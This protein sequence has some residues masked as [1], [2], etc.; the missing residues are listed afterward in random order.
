MFARAR[1]CLRFLLSMPLIG[2]S[3]SI[4]QVVVSSAVPD[5]R[6]TAVAGPARHPVLLVNPRAGDGKAQRFRLVEQC[7]TRGI[8][9]VV[10]Q[11]EDDLSELARKAISGGA[12]VVGA[13]G[14]DGSQ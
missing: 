8:E 2:R 12:D 11:G 6:R 4:T 7:R 5:P 10:I 14:G 13:A 1:G 9:S 3:L